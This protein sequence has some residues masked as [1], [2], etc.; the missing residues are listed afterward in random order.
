[1]G[2]APDATW[3]PVWAGSQERFFSIKGDTFTVRTG[4]QTHPSFPDRELWMVAVAE[5][6]SD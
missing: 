5:R 4:R 3:D 6:A 1:M 2:A